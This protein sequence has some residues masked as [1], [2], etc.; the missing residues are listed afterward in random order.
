[1]KETDM[2]KVFP[3]DTKK[4][5]G[6][7]ELVK[8]K[9]SSVGKGPDDTVFTW[10]HLLIREILLF[11]LVLVVILAASL[12]F[13]APL[14][15]PANADH[16]PNPSKAPWYF[17][18]IQ[19]LVSYSAFIGGILVPGLIVLGLLLVPYIDRKKKGIG[20][21]FAKER[22]MANFLFASFLIIMAIL[23]VI[24]VWFRGENWAFV[25]PW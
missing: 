5:Y 3:R 15:E 4:T 21:W 1:M 8:G 13:D 2:N 12:I 25:F 22:R 14:E 6:L 17:L 23:T 16:P 20:I 19:E 24:G 11:V 18:G 10:P 9:T 7:M